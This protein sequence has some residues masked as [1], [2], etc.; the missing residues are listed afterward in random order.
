MVHYLQAPDCDRI[1][2][3]IIIKLRTDP[4]LGPTYNFAT[5]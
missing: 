2:A 1:R 5:K 3:E 4:E